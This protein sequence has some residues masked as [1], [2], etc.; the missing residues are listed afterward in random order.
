MCCSA[1]VQ[2]QDMDKELSTVADKL[3]SS[4]KDHGNKKVTVVDFTD[5]DGGSSEL[6]R[7]AAEQLTVDL[8]MAKREFSVLDRA[9]L[10]R[11]LAELK[12]TSDGLVDPEN[13]KKLG[14]FS[15]V[16]ALILGTVT[17]KGTNISLTAKII[18]TDTAE[19]VGAAKAEFRADD[20]V[21]Q[22]LSHPAASVNASG[23]SQPPPAPKAKPFGDLQV[24]V[25]SLKFVN[26]GQYGLVTLTLVIT[27]SSE[28]KTYG[29]GIDPGQRNTFNLSNSRGDEFQSTEVTGI[30]TVYDRDDNVFYGTMTDVLPSSSILIVTK[31]QCFW[32]GK[33][34]DYRP[35]RFQAVLVFGEEMNGR[36]P[37]LKKYNAILDIK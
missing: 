11:I 19:I 4:I 28:S 24:K 14:M 3:A 23:E 25:E 31:S 12:L 32:N 35:F 15:G 34:G 30:N 9:N 6:G 33:G 1:L 37:N 2:A 21:Q 27:N 8:V 29:V 16:D 7:Y 26:T 17:P 36:H 22:F 20:T 18:T 5:L 13:A 10:K